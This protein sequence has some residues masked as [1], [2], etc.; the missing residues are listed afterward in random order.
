MPN[1]VLVNDTSL[2]APHFG[3][4][5]VGQTIR[6]QLARVSLK[7]TA[8][9]PRKFNLAMAKSYF[10]RADLVIINAEGTLHHGRHTNLLN[11]ARSWPCALING[12]FENNGLQPALVDF[13]YVAMRESLSAKE[14][15]SQNVACKVVPDLL[16]AST[17]LRSVPKI[18]P[19]VELGITDNVL[20][21]TAG[22]SPTGAFPFEV[23]HKI[24]RCKTLCAGRFHAAVTA[25]VLGVP[26]STWDS[27]TWKTRGMMRDMGLPQLHFDTQAEAIRRQP[28]IRKSESL[29]SLLVKESS[30]CLI[31]WQKLP[32]ESPWKDRD[33]KLLRNL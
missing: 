5:L 1:V 31:R 30:R 23:V 7:L 3:C 17:M 21:H 25:A 6:E 32:T 33:Q 4:Q 26:F 10:D 29:L 2:Y 22:F 24:A 19:D 8:S 13:Q 16:F 20:N 15:R 18:Q 14:I 28:W 9:F 27:N 12:V 11:L